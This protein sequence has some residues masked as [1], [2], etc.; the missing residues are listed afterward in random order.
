MKIISHHQEAPY[1]TSQDPHGYFKISLDTDS[2][3]IIVDH[4]AHTH[5]LLEEYRGKSA[6]ELCQKLAKNNA[7]SDIGHA[8]YMGTQLERAWRSQ[9]TGEIYVQ[10]KT[11]PKS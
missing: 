8:M 10:D 11:R 3:E 4:F 7:I 2:K 9:I 6:P 5:E 1:R